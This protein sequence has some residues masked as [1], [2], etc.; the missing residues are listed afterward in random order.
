MTPQY[1]TS[2]FISLHA[3]S[4]RIWLN[5]NKI[6]VF[7]SKLYI[8]TIATN[9]TLNA[10]WTLRSRHYDRDQTKEPCPNFLRFD[11]A[12]VVLLWLL[13][14]LPY[15]LIY[16]R[17]VDLSVLLVRYFDMYTMSFTLDFSTKDGLL[18]IIGQVQRKTDGKIGPHWKCARKI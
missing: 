12:S 6:L 5:D 11:R 13:H 2:L 16:T 4:T 9:K 8:W 18:L 3:K 7:I 10:T 14:L 15:G 17:W 1:Y